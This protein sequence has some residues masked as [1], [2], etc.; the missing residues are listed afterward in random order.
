MISS[1]PSWAR[2]VRMGGVQVSRSFSLRPDIVTA[3]L[4]ELSGTAAVP[5]AIDVY[6]NNL[7]VH[8]GE[9]APGPFSIQNIPA[10]SQGGVARLVM[11]DASGREVVREQRFYVSP[12]LLRAGLAEFSLSAGVP[13][14]GYGSKS[15][16]Y[17]WK[18]PGIVASG[19]YGLSNSLTLEG[20]AE[21]A[22]HL[23]LVGGG[24][25]YSLFG[26]ALVSVSGAVS[27]SRNG[28]GF[29]SNVAL[30]T[31]IGGFAINATSMRT[32]GPYTDLAALAAVRSG[33]TP[34]GAG[35]TSLPDVPRAVESLN[36]GYTFSTGTSLAASLVHAKPRKGKATDSLNLS[37]SQ[38]LWNKASLYVTGLVDLDNPKKPSVFAGFSMPLGGGVSTSA[39]ANY[40]AQGRYR[41]SAS[42]SKPLKM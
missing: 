23:A 19:R 39:S 12:R 25:N 24:V 38:T 9:V 31:R 32:Y 35:I 30:E 14:N 5:T 8:S 3:P 6:V 15:F 36:V 27:H 28:T 42:V 41:V 22:P 34:G 26:Q 11:R 40:D 7:K 13:R 29:L 17:A 2:P 1:G 37:L 16:D 21:A 4:P 10:I 33:P 18:K 20:H